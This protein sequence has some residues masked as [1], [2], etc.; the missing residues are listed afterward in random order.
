MKETKGKA[1]KRLGFLGVLL[2]VG[3]I[4]L[5][6]SAAILTTLT[7]N[8]VISNMENDIYEKLHAAAT[9]LA[10]H[11][12]NDIAL[13]GE[14]TYDHAYVDGLVEQRVEQTLFLGDTRYVTSIKGADGQRVEGTTA[15]A[16]IY[17][18]VMTGS[19]Y[20]AKDVAIGGAL[21]YVCYVPLK[22]AD[23]SIIGMGFAGAPEDRI[24]SQ[25]RTTAVSFIALAGVLSLLCGAVVITV[26]FKIRRELGLVV[27]MMRELAEGNLC[28]E[29]N[30]HS[31]IKE[32]DELM[33]DAHE[34]EQSMKTVIATVVTDVGNMDAN[35]E[36]IAGEV[37]NCNQASENILSAVDELSKGSVDMAESVQ[38]T[39]SSMQSMGDGI[40]EIVRLAKDATEASQEVSRES[41]DAQIKLEQLGEANTETEGISK[42]VVRGIHDSAV[43]VENIRKAADV[44]AQIAS[45]TSLL[46]LNASIEAARAGDAGRGFAVVAGEISNLAAQSNAST[47]EI[48][49]VVAEIIDSSQYNVEL[50]E[51][52]KAAV[53]HEGTVLESVS[54]SFKVVNRKVA[55]STEAIHA[56]TE[57]ANVLDA[58]KIA[59]LDE[60]STLSSIS[61]ENAAS[62]EETNASM[63][64]LKAN[65]E[66]IHHK[67]EGTNDLSR[68]LRETTGYF[69]LG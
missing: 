57:K 66:D 64:E 19:E 35:M 25:M 2:C 52:I 21:Y 62:C 53:N 46:A 40:T 51:R 15:D 41:M 20:Y 63:E 29:T 23:G 28:V 58:E 11:Y 59:I 24:L 56:I 4:P 36:L 50:A 42:D 37:D 16:R 45:Q 61:E 27:A 30:L 18:S 22:G 33:L 31:D 14:P 39:A 60:V 34:M 32:I 43:A 1:K 9:G 5:L 68:E 38:H 54:N 13:H 10:L 69:K 44:I 3:L 55:E 49:K 7:L 17:E 12:E 48:K 47:V 8:K 65:M 67:A 6:V 26:A